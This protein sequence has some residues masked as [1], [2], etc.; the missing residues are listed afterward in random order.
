MVQRKYFDPWVHTATRA[1]E[2]PPPERPGTLFV[3]FGLRALTRHQPWGI[4]GWGL[5]ALVLLVPGPVSAGPKDWPPEALAVLER[6]LGTWK[7]ETGMR[8]YG[9]TGHVFRTEGQAESRRTLGDRYI[10]FRSQSVSADRAELQIMT[11]DAEAKVYRQWLF[12]SDGYR[13]TAVG[14]WNAS[15][16]TLR[17]EGETAETSFVISDHWKSP[18]RLEWKLVRKAAD[19]RHLQTIEGVLT[20]LEDR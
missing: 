10:E 5:L 18:V 14:Q 20:R 13:H 16:S 6:F 2:G 7:T 19:G 12:D 3:R 1:P 11:Y 9:P 4:F 15:S 8:S 17:W